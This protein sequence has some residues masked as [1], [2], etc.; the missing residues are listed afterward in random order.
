MKTEEIRRKFLEYF[1]SKNHQ[2]VDSAP[3]VIKNDPTLMFT[4]AGM[5]QFK[6]Y[7]LGNTEAKDKRVAD[8]QKC[9]RVSGKH[10]DLEEVGV[11]TYHHT[12]FEMLGNWSFGDYFKEEAIDWAWDLLTNVFKLD[13]ERLYITVF[14]GDEKDGVPVD[15][16]SID[17]WKKHVPEER[18]LKCDKKDNF[19]EMGDQ[20]PCGPCS[21]IHM[22]IRSEEE[23]AKI[24]G[25][26]MVNQDHPQVIEIWNLVFMQF[27]RKADASLEP[28]PEKHVDT[29]MGLERLAMVIQGVTSNYDTDI[30]QALISDLETISGKKYGENEKTD[31]AFRVISDHIRA[32]AF[33]ITDGQLPSN[34]GAGYV[35]RRILRRAIRYG[36]QTLELKEPFINKLVPTL[37][38]TMG[39]NFTELKTQQDII[40]KVILEEEQS[41]FRT[42]EQGLRLINDLI[43]KTKNEGSKTLSG[44]K[45]FELYDTFGFPVDLTSLI[46]RENDLEVDEAGFETELQKQKD[47]SRQAT[48]I[49]SGDWTEL[50]PNQEEEFTGYDSTQ[51]SIKIVRYRQVKQKKKE[52]FQMVF[53]KT[54]FYAE[55][56]G[57]VGDSG[58]IE[59]NGEKTFI[60]D[61][62]RENNLIVHFAEKLPS[63][64]EGEFSAVVNADKRKLTARN[65]TATHLLHYALRSVLGEHV[66]QK[67]SLVNSEYLRFD[68]SHFSKMEDEE[69]EKVEGMVNQMIE[70]A[71]GLEEYRSIAIE[72]AK[73]KGAMA[74]FGEKYGDTVRMI[75]FGDSR[76]LCGGIHVQNTSEIRLFKIKSESAIAA[77]IRRVE[78]ITSEKAIAFFEEAEQVK[79]EIA[80]LMKNPKDLV[81]SVQ[82]LMDK[83]TALSKEIE[84]LK[85]EKAGAFKKELATKIEDINGINFLGIKTDLD[86]GSIKNILFQ[87]KAEK[88]NLFAIIGTE[89]NGK[90]VLSIAIS[91]DLVASKEM[92]AGKIVRDLAGKHIQGGGG[93]QKFF[94]TAGGRNAD[95]L[96]PAIEEA[97]NLLN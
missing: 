12:M 35:I 55:G 27:N 50:I 19:W 58:Y 36:Y 69:I 20:G 15:Q 80:E 92:D 68:F 22:D 24:P 18:I 34:T 74:L 61:T 77:G 94:A 13:K 83:N 33:S 72:E 39:G 90:A 47:R 44:E 25:R 26:D 60:F 8:T 40:T 49:E 29:G 79:S 78:A 59:V 31:I 56:G 54:P 2:I 41:F 63:N 52:F 93:G 38:S 14:E 42:L 43:Q 86:A 10:N 9:L 11:D 67:G 21:E 76:E 28:L 7:F 88:D 75:Q 37:V 16:E 32:I 97:K 3:M 85:S 71:I 87:L 64:L 81:K 65:H 51:E 23:I 73:A 17:F 89:D 82:E 96:Q 57:Q 46:A 45:V 62:K 5:N 84:K 95:G 53:D 4:N 66:E 48:S 70:E 91:D 1:E 30:F 6:E